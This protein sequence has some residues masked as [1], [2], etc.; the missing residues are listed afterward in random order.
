[1]ERL[2]SF[3]F[4]SVYNDYDEK[5]RPIYDRAVGSKM[6]RHAFAQFFSSGI[7]P[8]PSD[9][10]ML[11]RGSGFDVVV[12]YGEAIIDG[13]FGGIDD[14]NGKAFTL[15]TEPPRG[16][17]T[18]AFFVRLDDNFDKR[19]LYIR[20]AETAGSAPAEP[21]AVEGA[22]SELRLGYVTFPSN[23]ASVEDAT[24]VDERGLAVC[25]YAAPFEDIDVSHILDEVRRTAGMELDSFMRILSDNLSFIASAIDGTAAGNLQAQINQLNMDAVRRSNLDP[26]NLTDAG[27][28]LVRLAEGAADGKKIELDSN[29]SLT[30]KKNS[31]SY[32]DLDENAKDKIKSNVR[33]ISDMVQKKTCAY[34]PPTVRNGNRVYTYVHTRKDGSAV[35][36]SYISIE[37]TKL[38]ITGSIPNGVDITQTIILSGK[39]PSGQIEKNSVN[40]I[41]VTDNDDGTMDVHIALNYGGSSADAAHSLVINHL[42]FTADGAFENTATHFNEAFNIMNS[43]KLSDSSI[44]P[45]SSMASIT[46]KGIVYS[47]FVSRYLSEAN[48]INIDVIEM[49]EDGVVSL[50][51]INTDIAKSSAPHYALVHAVSSQ[52]PMGMYIKG[53]D[54]VM[55]SESSNNKYIF[56]IN[57]QKKQ[58]RQINFMP[59]STV[60]EDDSLDLFERSIETTSQ[61]YFVNDQYTIIIPIVIHGSRYKREDGSLTNKGEPFFAKYKID[62]E[63][64]KIIPEGNIGNIYGEVYLSGNGSQ[65][66][67]MSI[68][69]S[70]IEVS[71]IAIEDNDGIIIFQRDYSLYD[72]IYA[73][74]AAEISPNS[75][76][77]RKNFTQGMTVQS[78]SEGEW[79]TLKPYASSYLNLVS[80]ANNAFFRRSAAPEL[81]DGVLYPFG[82]KYPCDLQFATNGTIISDKL[83]TYSID[84]TEVIHDETTV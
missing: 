63:K 12:S 34:T 76:F 68:S 72:S 28:G 33:L 11:R 47:F 8:Q 43:I 71:G 15:M 67:T 55:F 52:V 44:Q 50:S 36:I 58:F 17:K 45:G 69:D 25:P 6:L 35:V 41:G 48:R 31:I 20:V 9:N 59:S 10:L 61:F 82:E 57:L 37:Q 13:A 42:L 39:A 27:T 79:N 30:I 16:I 56:N 74:L 49:T 51:T 2:Q 46:D 78:N 65:Y 7:F 60:G 29:N 5:G 73:I 32:D 26:R 83:M 70:P 53:T 22:V 21:E 23:A 62:F 1:M 18:Y 40:L 84:L 3:P 54:I 4:T 77:V 66:T 80:S 38:S 81:H 14:V 75:V 64:N 24:L 19:S